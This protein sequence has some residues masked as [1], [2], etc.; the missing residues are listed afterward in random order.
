MPKGS[1]QNAA[2]VIHRGAVVARYAKHHLPNY[3]VFDE[4]RY[5][6]PGNDALVVRTH[7]VDVAVSICEDIWQDGP[8]LAARAA[9]A[10]LMVVINGSPYEANKDDV[11]AELCAS[12]GGRGRMSARLR[13]HGRRPGRARLRRRLDR[14]RP[15]P[16]T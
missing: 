11:R 1:P 10:G 8:S 14:G 9:G 6:V 5:F 15:R 12:P 7:G 4:Y 2:A 16:V 3:G 13:Q